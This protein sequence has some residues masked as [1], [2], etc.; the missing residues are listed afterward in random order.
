LSREIFIKSKIQIKNK[1]NGLHFEGQT[2]ENFKRRKAFEDMK[3][4][5]ITKGKKKALITRIL[6]IFNK[7]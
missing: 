4:K 7:C 6:R 3:E 5:E 1:K 2:T